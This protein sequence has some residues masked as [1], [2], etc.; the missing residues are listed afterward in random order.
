[1]KRGIVALGMIAM[2]VALPVSAMAQE[3]RA[4]E[5][6]IKVNGNT[7]NM[8]EA[9]AYIEQDLTYVPLRFVSE[10]LGAKVEYVDLESPITTT[11]EEPKHNEVKVRINSN[12]VG[13]NGKV[14]KIAGTPVLQNGRTMVPIRVI[15]EGLGAEVKWIPGSGGSGI[16]EINTPW[17]T[18]EP[19]DS[20]ESTWNPDKTQKEYAAKVFK[21]FQWNNSTRTL[22]FNI[23]KMPSVNP[24]IGIQYGT[25]KE[26]IILGKEYTFNNLPSEFK[27]DIT[28]FTDET[29]TSAADEYTVMSYDYANSHKWADGLS[30]S[31]LVVKDQ[32]KNNV[33]LSNVNKALGID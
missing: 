26:K 24:M 9:P 6:T 1:M 17:E 5:V 14:E 4:N 13:I 32:Y 33:T 19:A 28:I 29:F 15:S 11:I 7:I 27:I 30:S 22:T 3:T 23:A 20:V 25:T 12:N 8:Y 10:A 16:V 31:D 18:P 2:L 21:E